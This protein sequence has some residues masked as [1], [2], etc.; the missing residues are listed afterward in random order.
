[1]G[2]PVVAAMAAA[3]L[4]AVACGPDATPSSPTPSPTPT[5]ADAPTPAS[6]SVAPLP[7]PPAVTPAPTPTPT[8]APTPAPAP[9]LVPTPSPTPAATPSPTPS[10]SPSPTAAAATP[11]PTPDFTPE[12]TLRAG[13]CTFLLEVAD[14]GEEKARGLMNRPSLPADRGMIFVYD[15][16]LV[17]RFWMLNTLIPLDILFID[18]R[19]TV[20]DIQTMAP[21]P[22]VPTSELTIYE[23]S[24]PAQ[25]ALE[26]NAGMAERCGIVVGAAVT[27]E[28]TP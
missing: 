22:G 2:L 4:L 26:V 13:S 7:T 8:L 5:A 21:E 23:S 10:P 19:N 3:V 14:T 1:M 15:A 25:H 24:A 9:T 28:L 18:S 11:E 6:G 27:L 20:V 16:E 17:L 12:G